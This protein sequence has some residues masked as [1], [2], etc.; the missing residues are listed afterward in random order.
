[1]PLPRRQRAR[2]LS[3]KVLFTLSSWLL[4]Q[5]VPMSVLGVASIVGLSLL[6]FP[7]A[8]TIALLTGC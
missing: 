8:F 5:L 7:L 3:D 1:M 6:G 2:E 4:G